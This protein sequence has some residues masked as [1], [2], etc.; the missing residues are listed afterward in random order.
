LLGCFQLGF[1]VDKV[2]RGSLSQL[3]DEQA[4]PKF[5]FASVAKGV[6]VRNY[7]YEK[8]CRLNEKEANSNSEVEL[9]LHMCQVAHQARAYYSFC[10]M[11]QLGVFLLPP[12]WDAS[13]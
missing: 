8:V 9:S 3:M 5:N 10:S 6:F 1:S 11:K 13:P 4:N 7:S 12:G 2:I